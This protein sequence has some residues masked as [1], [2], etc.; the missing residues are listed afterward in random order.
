M[1]K[2][3]PVHRELIQSAG[4]LLERPVHQLFMYRQGETIGKFRGPWFLPTWAGGLGLKDVLQQVD[5]LDLQRLSAAKLAISQGCKI[6]S[7]PGLEKEWIHYDLFQR[8][9]RDRNPLS[10]SYVGYTHF[11]EQVTY[12]QAF[13]L[14]CLTY[15]AEH[16]LK[17]LFEGSLDKKGRRKAKGVSQIAKESNKFNKV[18]DSL[19]KTTVI[20]ASSSADL[21]TIALQSVE[22]IWLK[23][24]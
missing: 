21:E 22:P 9:V 1:N 10:T 8:V 5:Y 16:G 19:I 15:W 17:S 4:T 13:M 11:E 18:L 20:G 14:V 12:G 2:L 3:G 24:T 6:P 23:S 7:L